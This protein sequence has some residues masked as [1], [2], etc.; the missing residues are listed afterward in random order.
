MAGPE[1]PRHGPGA[2]AYQHKRALPDC[3]R[4]RPDWLR[5][6][7]GLHPSKRESAS[8]NSSIVVAALA[9]APARLS[10]SATGAADNSG[11]APS[12]ASASEAA[13]L[14]GADVS[15]VRL[16]IGSSPIG[17][18]TPIS[19]YHSSSARSSGAV[20]SGAG[21]LASALVSRRAGVIRNAFR[22]AFGPTFCSG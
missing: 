18:S 6:G 14:A 16:S 9:A 1:Y 19:T 3:R 10:V 17:K 8:R 22:N 5:C 21:R 20:Q 15:T 13:G 11:G 2:F 7:G 4:R 12:P